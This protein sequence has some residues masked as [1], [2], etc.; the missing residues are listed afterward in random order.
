VQERLKGA[1]A[2]TAN[3]LTDSIHQEDISVHTTKTQVKLLEY[4]STLSSPL[5]FVF[6]QLAL[7]GVIQLTLD[8]YKKLTAKVT[9]NIVVLRVDSSVGPQNEGEGRFVHQTFK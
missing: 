9:G 5:V 2:N 6:S 3:E 4:L 7:E 8:T 1:L